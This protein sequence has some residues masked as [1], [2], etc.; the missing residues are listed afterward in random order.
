MLDTISRRGLI[1]AAALSLVAGCSGA[2]TPNVANQSLVPSVRQ[3]PQGFRVVPG[4]VVAGPR[5]V[6]IVPR[7][8]NAPHGW[9]NALLREVLF[10]AD[11]SSGV[12]L[13]NPRIVNASPKG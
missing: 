7:A 10:V 4:P 12:L 8:V 9:P 13:Y 2:S 3:V 5:I 11:S 6:P 1:A